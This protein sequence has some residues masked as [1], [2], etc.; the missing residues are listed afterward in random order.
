MFIKEVISEYFYP[1]KYILGF[2]SDFDKQEKIKQDLALTHEKNLIVLKVTQKAVCFNQG[3]FLQYMFITA[4]RHK[5]VK[6]AFRDY[7]CKKLLKEDI[8]YEQTIEKISRLVIELKDFININFYENTHENF[9]IMHAYYKHRSGADPRICVKGS[10]RANDKST[11]VS[12]FRDSKVEYDSD[13]DIELNTGFETIHKT[14]RYF[15]ENNIPEAATKNKYYNPRLNNSDVRNY[16]KTHNNS[17]CDCWEGKSS[18]TSCYKSTLI[19]PMTLW[20]NKVSEEFKK[21]INMDNV[22]RTIFGFLC[23]DHV[24]TD[25]FD[26]GDDVAVGY[27]FADI[28]SMYVFTR[29]IYMEI[30]KTFST[31]EKWLNSNEEY[32]SLKKIEIQKLDSLWKDIPMHLDIDKILETS[33]KETN[34]NA[35]I[36][37]DSDLLKFVEKQNN[38]NKIANKNII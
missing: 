31:V 19:V 29:S 2:I 35:L 26:E 1:I 28:L 18:E 7:Q 37:V 15:L 36:S 8:S 5:K 22:E 30:S 24:D 34:N 20:N 23:F 21:I 6:D 9:K 25:Y 3:A 32:E 4:E 38:I 11:I 33:P 12:V 17:W 16:L 27:I 10:F 13:A 14:G